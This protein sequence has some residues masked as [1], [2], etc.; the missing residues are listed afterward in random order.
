MSILPRA[1]KMT[2]TNVV[3]P[4]FNYISANATDWT[5][6]WKLYVNWDGDNKINMIQLFQGGAPDI[7]NCKEI[8]I[9]NLLFKI[10]GD[11]SPLA[12]LTKGK[13]INVHHPRHSDVERI[14]R[15][16]R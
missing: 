5:T 6:K 13:N 2:V 7:L 16:A 4:G 10:G 9:N 11:K 15:C 3:T 14:P 12:S 1:I 8:Y